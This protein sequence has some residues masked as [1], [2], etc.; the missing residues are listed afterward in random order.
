LF[1]GLTPTAML[2]EIPHTNRVELR[3]VVGP[4]ADA[5]TAKKLC[6]SL[7]PFR[8]FCQ[9]TVFDRQHAAL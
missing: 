5:E 1:D 8:L 9:P 2:R 4:L 7:A 6:A 3:L